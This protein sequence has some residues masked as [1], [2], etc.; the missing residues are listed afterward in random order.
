L[1]TEIS[2]DQGQFGAY[3]VLH[4]TG[5]ANPT[6]FRKSFQPGRDIDGIAEE[7]VALNHDV[8]DVERDPKPHLLTGRPIRI[9]LGYG[10]LNRDGTLNGVHGAGE[11][12][13]EAVTRGIENP[14]AMRGDQVIDDDPVG[15]ERSK[16]TD[17]I[18]AH[19]GAVARDIRGENR[20]ELSFDGW[21]FQGSAPPQARVYTDLVGDP[22]VL[23]HSRSRWRAFS[24]S[25]EALRPSQRNRRVQARQ[26]SFAASVCKPFETRGAKGCIQRG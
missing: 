21:R 1:L 6:R 19:E 18:A 5:D 4:N 24:D 3:M 9:L 25:D 26:G 10:V 20:S 12:G 22:R 15:R 14:T 2:E 8:A 11:V 17:L 16:G 23:N 7:V 13:D